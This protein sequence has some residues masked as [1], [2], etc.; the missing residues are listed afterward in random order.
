MTVG[1]SMAAFSWLQLNK[2]SSPI[3]E[4]QL[5]LSGWNAATSEPNTLS[6]IHSH[7]VLALSRV[8]MRLC[9]VVHRVVAF[10]FVFVADGL[11]RLVVHGG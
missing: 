6:F 9:V 10:F 3:Q 8:G 7:Y 5:E 2:Q 1:Y 11:V 4:S